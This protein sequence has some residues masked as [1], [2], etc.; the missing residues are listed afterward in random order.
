MASPTEAVLWRARLWLLAGCLAAVPAVALRGADVAAAVARDRVA[1][2]AYQRGVALQHAQRYDEAATAFRNAIATSPTAIGAYADLG[3]V[4]LS[5]GHFDEAVQAYR[6][7]MAIYPYTYF[8]ELYRRVGFIELRGGSFEAAVQD[9][10]Q[11][12][13][14]DPQDW[15]AFYLLGHAQYRLGDLQ[16]ARTTWERVLVLNPG[17]QPANE[18][19]RQ[20]D[21]QHR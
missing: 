6:R 13:A 9:L 18:R 11:A 3:D 2:A 1:A 10:R 7:L 14:L 15:H 19:L 20:L 16:A 8:G 21:A 17:F 5:Q 4:E 12:S